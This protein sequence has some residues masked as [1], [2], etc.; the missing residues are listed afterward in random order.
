M[1][2]RPTLALDAA[3]QYIPLEDILVLAGCGSSFLTV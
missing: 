3:K 1:L 2:F